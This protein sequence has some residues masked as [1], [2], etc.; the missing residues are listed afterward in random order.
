MGRVKK[1]R[2]MISSFSNTNMRSPKQ[3]IVKIP[4]ENI[5]NMEHINKL[6]FI[7]LLNRDIHLTADSR[8]II[9]I[10]ESY[11]QFDSSGGIVTD[12]LINAVTIGE[13][14]IN[15][16][17]NS[18][19]YNKLK[20]KNEEKLRKYEAIIADLEAKYEENL[21]SNTPGY[22]SMDIKTNQPTTEQIPFL[23]QLAK[24][25]GNIV[26]PY[27]HA[28]YNGTYD[29]RAPLIHD[30][31]KFIIK[32]VK[33]IGLTPDPSTGI[34]PALKSLQELEQTL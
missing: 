15:L 4:S 8:K 29:S 21:D 2:S 30:K 24:M 19:L 28:Y 3:T 22:I 7:P 18:E 20:I 14:N 33:S 27:Y 23:S 16:Y 25:T 10:L 9:N 6:F 1:S 34:S 11:R 17:V 13:N 12:F 5:S 31:L 26:V 32:L